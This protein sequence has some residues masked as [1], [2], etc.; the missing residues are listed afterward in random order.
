MTELYAAG[1]LEL[2]T[3][4]DFL[5]APLQSLFGDV[6]EKI[7]VSDFFATGDDSSQTVSVVFAVEEDLF[8][9]LPSFG[10]TG[11][12][13][14]LGIIVDSEDERPL[15]YCEIQ[16]GDGQVLADPVTIRLPVDTLDVPATLADGGAVG[17]GLAYARVLLDL[18]L[19]P[20]QQQPLP[21]HVEL[22]DVP[23]VLRPEEHQPLDGLVLPQTVDQLEDRLRGGEAGDGEID[24]D[25]LL[26]ELHA[27]LVE[28]EVTERV[29]GGVARRRERRLLQV[30]RTERQHPL[31]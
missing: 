31:L 5:V 27:L 8:V 21:L 20:P 22:R 4:I 30:H 10:A 13:L 11:A 3:D 28:N 6:L 18:G 2:V 17:A 26:L 25:L 23:L 16:L 24:G 15:I 29:P 14:G 19:L 1:D 12:G 9:Q 7:R